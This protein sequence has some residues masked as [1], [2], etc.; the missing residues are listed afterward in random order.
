M[1]SLNS[2]SLLKSVLRARS[3]HGHAP[4]TPGA[5]LACLSIMF[6]I[7]LLAHEATRAPIE[8]PPTAI[9]RSQAVSVAPPARS[10]SDTKAETSEMIEPSLEPTSLFDDEFGRLELPPRKPKPGRDSIQPK[11]TGRDR[12]SSEPVAQ[13][14]A[15]IAGIWAPDATTCSAQHFRDGTLPAVINADGAWAGDTFCT[16][17]NHKQADAG[18]RVMASCSSPR[19]HW[20]TEVHLTVKDNRLMW[21]SKRGT[22]A[23]ARC[24]PDFRVAAAR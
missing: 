18:W 16:F 8:R 13:P 7:G 10:R 24:G 15:S 17:K 11:Q 21:K 20:T 19:E 23:Y 4:V 22:Q 14:L 6:N 5:L 3:L 12:A 2:R 9:P 1:G